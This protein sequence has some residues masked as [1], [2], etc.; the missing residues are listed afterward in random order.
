MD[1]VNILTSPES[2]SAACHTVTQGL[3]SEDSGVVRSSK[4]RGRRKLR[5]WSLVRSIKGSRI[6]GWPLVALCWA[7]G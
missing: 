5:L 1:K 4:T 7:L 2:G 6:L 3:I